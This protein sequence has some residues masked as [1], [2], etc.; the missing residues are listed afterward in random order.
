MFLIFLFFWCYCHTTN[1]RVDL[2]Q[3]EKRRMLLA[4]TSMHR[5]VYM[6]TTMASLA[7]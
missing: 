3:T 4:A 7:G 1:F 5:N 2:F 6:P